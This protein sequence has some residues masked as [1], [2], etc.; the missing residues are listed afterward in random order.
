M[1]AILHQMS[2]L[3]LLP[4]SYF[5]ISTF[6]PNFLCSSYFNKTT[7]RVQVRH[8]SH[9]HVLYRRLYNVDLPI[10]LQ[11]KPFNHTILPILAYAY[12]IP[13]SE[14]LQEYEK[15]HLDYLRKITNC[16]NSTPSYMLCG[17][18]GRTHLKIPIQKRMINYWRKLVLKSET[19]FSYIVYRSMCLRNT[20]QMV[21]KHQIYI[22]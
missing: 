7:G 16:R 20:L 19:F 13:G 8:V 4:K 12:E 11:L 17:E 9:L 22:K 3:R 14:N 2:L 5:K 1:P 10:D 21:N 18:L 15:L 6:Q